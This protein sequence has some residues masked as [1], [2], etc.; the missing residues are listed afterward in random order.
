MRDKNSERDS[1]LVQNYKEKVL[2]G[3]SLTQ[4]EALKLYEEA[5]LEELLDAAD[6][7]RKHFC[8]DGFDLCT[9]INGKSGKCSENCRYCAQSV[10][11]H[12]SV[13]SY[14]LLN[15]EEMVSAA[16]K[17]AADGVLRFSIVTSGKALCDEEV[18]QVCERIRAI[19]SQA[20][21]EVCVSFGLLNESQFRKIK[22]AG[23]SR[24]HCNLETSRAYFPSV[25]TTH[26]FDDKI[27]T[28]QAARKAGLSICSGGIM[29]LGESPTDR[30]DMAFTLKELHV[31]SVP[32]NFLNPIAGTPFAQNALLSEEEKKRVIAVY[33]MILPDASI[34]LAGGRGLMPD[35]G[36][37]CFLGG[38]N[39]AITG[40]ML[41]TA[42]I[43]TKTDQELL[44][45]LGY[46]VEL[47][48]E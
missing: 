10:F 34:R 17:N 48:N 18:E 41:T 14:G 9:I 40:D 6:K 27:R 7:V 32:V 12:T 25:C 8:G 20:D 15:E 24:V 2:Q 31:R 28:L 43:S 13:E 3:E 35:K 5:P 37:G 30:I 16:R 39:A 29:G 4:E 46:K 26:T 23:A 22:E 44:K 1:G 11:Y 42:G 33:R 47:W 45:K 36:E 19:R 21:L 38:A